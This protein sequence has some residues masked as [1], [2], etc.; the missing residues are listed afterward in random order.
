MIITTKYQKY[1]DNYSLREGNRRGKGASA[2][3][4]TSRNIHL[5]S[6]EHAKCLLVA[7]SICRVYSVLKVSTKSNIRQ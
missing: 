4:V 2:I 1:F 5:E 3:K 6:V 7:I